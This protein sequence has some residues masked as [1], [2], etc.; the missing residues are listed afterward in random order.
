MTVPREP[1]L[2]FRALSHRIRVRVVLVLERWMLTSDVLAQVMGVAPAQMRRHLSLLQ[3]AGLVREILSPGK[4]PMYSL[5]WNSGVRAPATR[6]IRSVINWQS[7]NPLIRRDRVKL[8]SVLA[9][10]IRKERA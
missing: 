10:S 2:I 5:A 6:A 7:W 1:V 3:Q 8:A 9:G 4:P